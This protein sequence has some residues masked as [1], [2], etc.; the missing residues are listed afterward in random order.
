MQHA[1]NSLP[2]GGYQVHMFVGSHGQVTH[3]L[4]MLMAGVVLSND[5]WPEHMCMFYG[6]HVTLDDFSARSFGAV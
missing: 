2:M 6:H 5:T 4:S 3:I 1:K